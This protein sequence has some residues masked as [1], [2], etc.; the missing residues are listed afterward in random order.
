MKISKY[1]LEKL[2]K[3]L[4]GRYGYSK[5]YTWLQVYKTVEEYSPKSL[6]TI[7]HA[8]ALYCTEDMFN[9]L[10]TIIKRHETYQ[11]VREKY[12]VP[13]NNEF[14]FFNKT[15]WNLIFPDIGIGVAAGGDGGYH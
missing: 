7:T 5:Y 6:K 8:Y 2:P 12:G 1:I 13:K 4:I 11:N 9:L 15:D 10:N 3:Q 14:P